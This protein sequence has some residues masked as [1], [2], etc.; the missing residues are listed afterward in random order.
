MTQPTADIL[1]ATA[2]ARARSAGLPYAGAL[3]PSEA[4]ELL[5]RMP[6]AV[7]VD[8]RTAAELAWVGKPLIADSQ[9][10]HVEWTR[11]PGGSANPDFLD[12]L[13]AFADLDTPVLLLCRSA[14]RSKSAAKAAAEVGFTQVYDI[15]EGFEGDKDA[16]G[17][18][19]SVGGWCWH[20][21]PWLGA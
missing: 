2:N 21:L 13:R 11:Y 14:A 19:K 1:F 9:Y 6:K 18:R 20:Q 3:T 7:L 12:S 16:D 17:H 10:K 5:Q 4:Y 8:V 15:L